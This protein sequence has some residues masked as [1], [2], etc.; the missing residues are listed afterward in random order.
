MLSEPRSLAMDARAEELPG[1]A[2]RKLIQRLVSAPAICATLAGCGAESGYADDSNAGSTGAT[3][4]ALNGAVKYI[5]SSCDAHRT[6]IDEVFRIAADNLWRPEMEECLQSGVHSATTRFPEYTLAELRFDVMTKVTCEDLGDLIVAQAPLGI[7]VA[8]ER[9]TINPRY[10]RLWSRQGVADA[11]IHEVS[12]N[13]GYTHAATENSSPSLTATG[14]F[15]YKHTVPEQAR[16]CS[17]SINNGESPVRPH[18]PPRRAM[19]TEATLAPVGLLGGAPY[20]I[21]CALPAAGLQVRSADLIDAIG[22]NCLGFVQPREPTPMAGGPA[23]SYST[24]DCATG[25]V[26]VGV[27]GAAE[28]YL[29]GI[30]ALC[31]SQSS[32]LANRRTAADVR[33]VG[34]RG[35]LGGFTFRRWCPAGMV[36][37]GIRGKAGALVDR[38]EVECRRLNPWSFAVDNQ[39]PWAGGTGGTLVVEKCAGRS[40]LTGLSAQSGDLV[41]R[42]GGLCA[43]VSTACASGVC[44]ESVSDTKHMLPAYGG[45]GGQV[46]EQTCAS[47]SAIVGLFARAGDLLDAVLPVCANAQ[48]WSG[49]ESETA[50]LL[51][52]IG[53]GGGSLTARM[54]P[55]GQFMTGWQIRADDQTVHGIGPICRDFQ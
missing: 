41:D 52:W 29:M 12:H 49:P 43:P 48:R 9:V 38:L 34:W 35:V 24:L 4:A 30:G 33:E 18:G 50:V 45:W 20:Q 3:R 13:K 15:E 51:S 54:C 32:V 47:G 17:R 19:G 7:G 26:L 10:L 11:V 27:H 2:R 1:M 5:D 23:G 16:Q 8:N 14:A 36:V 21:P 53:G 40:A 39:R 31:A 28:N 22:L 46:A 6:A 44:R 37:S 55:K 42:L 25:E